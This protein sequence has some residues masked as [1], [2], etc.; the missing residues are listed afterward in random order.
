[1]KQ[2]VIIG[3][4]GM[5]RTFLSWIKE[6]KGYGTEF[7]IKG[8]IDDNIKALESFDDY[9]P[10]IGMITGYDPGEDDV[11]ICAVGGKSRIE[12]IDKILMKH[13]KFINIIHN[14]ARIDSHARIGIG[15]TIG[16]YVS[17]G[18]DAKVGDFNLIQNFAI[19]GHDV[20]IG[21]GNRL[22]TR[23]LCVANVIIGNGATVHS[24]S[25]IGYG[26]TVEDNSTVGACSFV[27]R[28][29]KSGTTVFGNTAKKI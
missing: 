1:M 28:R 16:P 22:D 8:F 29:V 24:S 3:A 19:I 20:V 12:C 21:N 11:F 4:G 2:L 7:E 13:G 26:V 14:T 15:N 25:V 5:G 18:A 10:I 23:V 6:S 17:I 27:I 9:P